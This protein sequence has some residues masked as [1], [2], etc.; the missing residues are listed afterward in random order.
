MKQ[1]KRPRVTEHFGR[2]VHGVGEGQELLEEYKNNPY[3]RR[4]VDL[5]VEG[6]KA[7]HRPAEDSED[8]E[9]EGDLQTL[10]SRRRQLRKS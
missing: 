6:L 4:K 7:N 1:M 3:L 10:L 5:L 2:V 9:G 8:H